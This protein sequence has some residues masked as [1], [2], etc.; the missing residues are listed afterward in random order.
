M[1]DTAE[2]CPFE[3][4]CVRI[5]FLCSSRPRRAPRELRRPRTRS[6]GHGVRPL[7]GRDRGLRA[8]GLALR[9]RPG[10]GRAGPTSWPP[11]LRQRVLLEDPFSCF[12]FPRP[13][14]GLSKLQSAIYL[15]GPPSSSSSSS[16]SSLSFLLLSTVIINHHRKFESKMWKRKG[17][18]EIWSIKCDYVQTFVCWKQANRTK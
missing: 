13:V 8:R 10:P 9:P 14:F 18:E 7:G 17:D 12:A 3:E 11:A 16:S 15:L 6:P 2:D 4:G 1:S 5:V